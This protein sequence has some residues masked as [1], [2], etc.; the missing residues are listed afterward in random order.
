MSSSTD[1]LSSSSTTRL[2][3]SCATSQS[4]GCDSS[5]TSGSID[6]NLNTTFDGIVARFQ[7]NQTLFTKRIEELSKEIDG[8]LIGSSNDENKENEE[9]S[10]SKRESKV[11][12]NT[13]IEDEEEADTSETQNITN[14]PAPKSCCASRCCTIFSTAVATIVAIFS[15]VIYMSP[16]N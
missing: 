3:T 11:E 7:E 10:V 13:Q 14:D 4:S 8:V 6:S 15:F 5:T 9:T 2:S 1:S 12:E 16:S